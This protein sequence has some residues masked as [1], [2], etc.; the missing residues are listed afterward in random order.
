MHRPRAAHNS[1]RPPVRQAPSTTSS[2]AKALRRLAQFVKAL[3]HLADQIGENLHFDRERL[4]GRFGDFAFQL[5]KFDRR[6]T[7]RVGKALA[8]DENIFFA[9]AVCRHAVGVTSM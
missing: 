8:M 1:V 4:V 5:A 6:E 3:H 7:R 9:R 2:A